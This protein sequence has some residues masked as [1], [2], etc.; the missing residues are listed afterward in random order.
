MRKLII[1]PALAVF[2]AGFTALVPAELR[3]AGV[4][5]LRSCGA[6]CPLACC[7]AGGWMCTCM[8]GENGM[9]ICGCWF[10]E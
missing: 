3:A 2:L 10:D 4:E 6:D 5:R 1:V 9:A 7:Y 8:C